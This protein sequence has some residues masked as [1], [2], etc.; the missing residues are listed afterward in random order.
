MTP[1]PQKRLSQT[2]TNGNETRN[3]SEDIKADEKKKKKVRHTKSMS[4]LVLKAWKSSSFIDTNMLASIPR[5]VPMPCKIY[6]PAEQTITALYK[7]GRA[8]Q[9]YCCESTNV[10]RS[11]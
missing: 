11:R 2:I 4:G 8:C 1:V 5:E 10:A 3:Q 7:L 6:S 9:A